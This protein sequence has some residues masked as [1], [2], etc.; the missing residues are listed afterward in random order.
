MT[1]L[2]FCWG[3]WWDNS[4]CWSSHLLSLS[5]PGQRRER[6]GVS[7]CYC[8]TSTWQRAPAIF[9]ITNFLQVLL[10]FCHTWTPWA[11]GRADN[12]ICGNSQNHSLEFS[13]RV[14]TCSICR[15]LVAYLTR[16]IQRNSR[17][18]MQKVNRFQN[19]KIHYITVSGF[20]AT[21][22]R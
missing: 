14:A 7:P 22:I 10:Q 19:T 1:W 8:D 9:S 12:C 16:K 17:L 3:I 11:V 13:E 2:T 21:S 4:Q 20:R 6:S 15:D 5:S 18:P